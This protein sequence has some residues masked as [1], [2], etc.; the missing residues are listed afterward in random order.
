M[1]KKFKTKALRGFYNSA[2]LRANIQPQE[3]KDV[4]MGHGRR[5]ARKHYPYDEFTIK[6]AYQRAFE[7]LTINGVQSREDLAK[8]NEKI[9]TQDK[10]INALRGI[11]LSLISREKLEA[12]VT[13]KLEKA[14]ETAKARFGE[15]PQRTVKDLTD[16][17]LW[18]LYLSL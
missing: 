5:N 13:E 14:P 11:L 9:E 16:K 3:L 7:H 15:A 1:A 4:M 18:Q 8:L 2:L 6:E 17:E 12:L 10:E